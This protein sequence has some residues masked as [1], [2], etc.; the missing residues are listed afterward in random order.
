MKET[1]LLYTRVDESGYCAIVEI[2][3]YPLVLA[4][5]GTWRPGDEPG[6]AFH[7]LPSWVA[8]V[9][10]DIDRE[11]FDWSDF[12]QACR[13][14]GLAHGLADVPDDP[15]NYPDVR[16][17]NLTPHGLNI[18]DKNGDVIIVPVSGQV[19]RVTQS[20]SCDY[21]LPVETEDG[22]NGGVIPVYTSNYGQV[23]GLTDPKE[24]TI[25]V[26]SRLVRDR[27]PKDRLDGYRWDVYSP[28]P[29]IRDADGKPIGCKGLY[30]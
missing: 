25:Y 3:S 26:V 29:L 6:D 27:L 17:I 24:G 30:R 1:L 14:Y 19:A 2:T 5:Q 13:E 21:T 20:D 10:T 4:T 7:S 28:G 15:D 16:I 12:C 8:G 9:R 18:A 11:D 22:E 23:V